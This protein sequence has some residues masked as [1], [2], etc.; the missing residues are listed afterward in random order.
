MS[1]KA[2]VQVVNDE[3]WYDNAI[4]FETESEAQFYAHDLY[5]RWTATVAWRVAVSDE[6][7]NYRLLENGCLEPVDKK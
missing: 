7:V 2:E 1:Y 3:K 4:R 6:P 5:N